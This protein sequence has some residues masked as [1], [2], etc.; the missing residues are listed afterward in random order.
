M[1]NTGIKHPHFPAKLFRW[2][3]LINHLSTIPGYLLI[4][5][6][7]LC[8]DRDRDRRTESLQ[9]T[10]KLLEAGVLSKV[11]ESNKNTDGSIHLRLGGNAAKEEE[12][13]VPFAVAFTFTSAA[14]KGGRFFWVEVRIH[15]FCYGKKILGDWNPGWRK[16][17]SY[18]PPWN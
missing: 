1:M 3:P 15:G 7:Q 2:N 18:Y 13:S 6:L 8:M 11:A 17:P 5:H 14:C 4:T 10:K 12:V 9:P 16:H